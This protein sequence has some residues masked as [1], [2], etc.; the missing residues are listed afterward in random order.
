M[1]LTSLGFQ[2]DLAL[3]RLG[4]TE[5][6][7]NGDHL[8]LR[9]PDNPAYWW[10]NFLLLADVP[11]PAESQHWLD[12]FAAEFPDAQHLAIGVDGTTGTADQLQWF[13]DRGMNAEAQAVMTATSVHLPTRPNPQAVYRQLI[14]DDD[15]TQNVDL[16]LRCNEDKQEPVRY[17][18]FAT[19]KSASYRRLIT[20]GHGGWFGAFVDGTLVAQMGLFR[21]GDGL[22]RFQSVETDPAHRRRGLAG[23][24]VHHVSEYGFA[25]LGAKT[26]VMVADPNYFAMELY[27][28]VGFTPTESQLQVEG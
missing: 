16:R 4:S 12:R 3:L 27:R 28:N 26:L 14:T 2:T 18:E 21:A 17:R 13:A 6:V 25:E 22:A 20:A 7:D 24:L 10:G 15:W 8:V 23:T 1:K 11:A 5:I 19:A 9:T